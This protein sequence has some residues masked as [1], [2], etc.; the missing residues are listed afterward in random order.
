MYSF[1][2]KYYKYFIL[3]ILIYLLLNILKNLINIYSLIVFILIF[4]FIYKN[5]KKILKKLLYKTIYKGKKA[6]IRSKFNAAKLSLEEISEINNRIKNKVKSELLTYEKNKLEEKLNIGD[7]NVILFGASSSGKTSL[8]RALLKSMVGRISPTIGTTREITSYKIRIPILKRNINI[9][10]TPGLFEPS[11]EGE[12]REKSTLIEASKS[13]LILFVLDQDINKYEL[14]I[15]KKLSEI[16]KKF[17][18]VLNKCD[19]RSEMQNRIVKDNI[20]SIISKETD[21]PSIIETIA[22]PINSKKSSNSLNELPKVNNL[23]KKI[24]E[25]LDDSGE[26][27]LADNILFRCKELGLVSKTYIFQQRALSAKKIINK[28]S[29]ITGG[30][31]LVNPLPVVDF[32]A[33]TSV[34]IQMIFEIAKIFEVKLT[35]NEATNL[36]KSL[37]TTIA[38]L[39][40]LKGGISL[41]TT[42]LSSN[43]TTLFVSKSIQSIT[44][45]WL[46]R[47]VG[48]S[49]IEYFKNDQKW[50]ENGIQGV[51]NKMYD[52]NKREE[53]LNNFI[54]EAINK[55]KITKNSQFLKKLPPNYPDL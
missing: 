14:Y 30:V 12:E 47:I 29:W 15:I 25:I 53:I 33:T 11:K 41:I 5:N 3:I 39:G 26:E 42:S 50:G 19:L 1:F 35:K 28:Y 31:I 54:D 8:A 52:L 51:V 27:L 4:L 24:I 48:L 55:L 18:V 37:I 43:F 46:M 38:N 20:S 23:F 6:S 9:I 34:N 49:L 21:I 40:I 2:F 32:L 22:N 7:Y 16:G 44:S 13:D 17:I 45:G 10:D 36:S